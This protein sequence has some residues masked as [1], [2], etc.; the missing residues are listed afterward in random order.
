MRFI[1][2]YED[3]SKV[4]Q[5]DCPSDFD[6][7]MTIKLI[8]VHTNRLSGGCRLTKRGKMTGGGLVKW[9]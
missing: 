2:R 7:V 6:L 1:R 4:Y 3:H 8:D 9:E 5:V